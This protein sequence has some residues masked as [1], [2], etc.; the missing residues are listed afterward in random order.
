M[1]SAQVQSLTITRVRDQARSI[2]SFDLLP[3]DAVGAHGVSFVPGQVALLRVEGEAPAYFAFAGTTAH[4]AV[5]Y[6]R[7]GLFTQRTKKQ[8]SY[9]RCDRHRGCRPAICVA[10]C[11]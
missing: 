1:E 7:A 11:L 5:R 4:G 6:C 3:K 8:S 10:P 9:Y 2:R